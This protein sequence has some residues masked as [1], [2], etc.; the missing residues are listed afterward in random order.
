MEQSTAGILTA[1]L[2]PPRFLFVGTDEMEAFLEQ[3]EREAEG[4]DDGEA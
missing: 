3:A 1:A 2:S 4:F